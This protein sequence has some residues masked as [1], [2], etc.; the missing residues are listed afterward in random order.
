MSDLPKISRVTGTPGAPVEHDFAYVN[1][2]VREPTTD[3]PDR[4]KIGLRAGQAQALPIL[5]RALRP[6]FR[7]LYIL[8]TSLTGAPLGRYESPDLDWDQVATFVALFNE[9]LTHDAR[10]DLWLHSFP[11]AATIVLDRYNMVYAYGPLD[12]FADILVEGGV[13]SVAAWAAP[14]V[15]YP[16]ALHYHPAF[17]ADEA[18]LLGHMAWHRKPLRDV[19]VQFWSGPQAS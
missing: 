10:H 1:T 7:L 18:A 3:G 17:T 13:Q 15:P 12:R 9:F 14:A 6:P 19:D 16:H 8:H 2:F 4:L 11:D 5:A